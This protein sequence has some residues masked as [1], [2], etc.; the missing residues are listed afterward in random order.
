MDLELLTSELDRILGFNLVPPVVSRESPIN[1][2]SSLLKHYP[3]VLVSESGRL[4]G[5]IT[6]SDLLTKLYGK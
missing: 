1:V 3:V 4:V 5:L 6:K 2:I